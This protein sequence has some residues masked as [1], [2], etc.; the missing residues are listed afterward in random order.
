MGSGH[1]RFALCAL[2]ACAA[3]LPACTDDRT[4]G[5]ETISL[6]G[7]AE[8][9]FE[10]IGS[11]EA[12]TVTDAEPGEDL[13]LV[14][15][16][17]EVQ[18]VLFT[19]DGHRAD[20]GTVD[21]QGTLAFTRVPPG[22]GYQVVSGERDDLVASEPFAVGDVYDEPD[23]SLYEDQ[24]LHE[25]LNFI[26]TR[27]GTT[28]AAMVR[29]P[30]ARLP[31]TP[32]G[33]PY[34][35]VIEYSGYSPADPNAPQPA[36]QIAD[37]Y[38]FATVG[39][40]IRGTG[41]SGGTFS[42]FEP[43]Q[44]SDG[45]DI[46]ETVAAQDWV[47]HHEVG[48]VGISYP[49]NSQLFVASTQPPSL[50]AIAP[51]SVIDDTYRAT[52]YPGGIYNNGFAREWAAQ[53][54]DAAQ[55]LGQGWEQF[56]N[57]EGGSNGE[58]CEQNQALR[59][60]NPDLNAVAEAYPF[61]VPDLLD[62]L[63][64]T[65][66][67]DRI[68]V[69]VFLAQAWQDEQTGGHASLLADQFTGSP[70]VHVVLTNGTHGDPL[71]PPTL[72]RLAEFLDFYV[73]RR[74]PEIPPLVR[75]G[76][77]AALGAVFGQG[78]L[79]IPPDRFTDA[80]SYDAALEEYQAEDPV[81]VLFESGSGT[82][83]PG[84]PG[85]TFSED[86]TSFPVEDVEPSAW[87]FQPDGG[88]DEEEPEVADGDDGSA[89]EFTYDPAAGQDISIEGESFPFSDEPPFAWQPLEEGTAAGYVSPALDE[90]LV[91]LGSAS[92]DLWV[93]ST[94]EDTDLE[95][96]LSEIRPNGEEVFV[97]GGWQ[98]ASHRALDE[99]ASTE[100]RP[101][102]THSEEDAAP[103]PEGEFSEVRVEVFPFGHVFREGSRIRVTVDSPGGNLSRWR[104]DSVDPGGDVVNTVAQ[105]SDFPSRVV[106]PV[107]PGDHD[108]PAGRPSC[109]FGLR[110]QPCR[111]YEELTNT[112]AG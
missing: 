20:E 89:A 69:P 62:P 34:P 63:A 31:G 112:A 48:M 4:D 54:Q 5:V 2:L 70:D 18:S 108:V 11:T 3:V 9:D 79:S 107:L 90:D 104:F 15:E 101:V 16:G 51:L 103:L 83:H 75:A 86:F 1:R 87:Y 56:V 82:D 14:D 29:F 96:T 67:V 100:L 58:T 22:E 10:V 77:P 105:S 8:A 6:D 46:V 64:P 99:D 33:G 25:G 102:H 40:N 72:Q 32:E 74:I 47:A 44:V 30:T 12:V 94:A 13:Q 50:A 28:L 66:F 84:T 81:H 61:Y 78:D 91:M 45:Y 57:D 21:E 53:V 27:D 35:T 95:V 38:G 7:A 41:C 55:P 73:A 71:A 106:L 109:P 59:S 49:G 43:Q 93:Q 42:F 26:E 36:T 92:A 23:A 111:E 76:A 97:Q 68:D 39:V 19:P 60:Q 52:L 17:G 24:E 65:T 110:G 88:L 85:E 37:A 80:E 98:R